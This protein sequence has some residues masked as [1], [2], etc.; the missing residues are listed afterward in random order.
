[1][2]VHTVIPLQR[3]KDYVRKVQSHPG[4]HSK[5]SWELNNNCQGTEPQSHP[6][7]L[8]PCL[9]LQAS[10][11]ILVPWFMGLTAALVTLNSGWNE[12]AFISGHEMPGSA[13]CLLVQL[14]FL[15]PEKVLAAGIQVLVTYTVLF[16]LL[17]LI[18]Y[19]RVSA[20]LET[21]QWCHLIVCTFNDFKMKQ[22][23]CWKEPPTVLSNLMT[24]H[25]LCRDCFREHG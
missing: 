3:Q 6:G 24:R 1:M 21:N 18:H 8:C 13:C 14:S 25:L 11:I 19:F 15:E 23:W 4:L 22:T 10:G 16:A 5:A 17:E 20:K 2:V 7:D 12:T 9:S